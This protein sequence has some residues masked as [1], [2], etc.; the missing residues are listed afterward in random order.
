MSKEGRSSF[1]EEKEAKRLLSIGRV[2]VWR[3]EPLAQ[4]C[5][6]F[7]LLFFKKEVLSLNAG[8]S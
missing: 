2:R 6:S 8:A 7:L 3:A 1:S 5:K 4:I